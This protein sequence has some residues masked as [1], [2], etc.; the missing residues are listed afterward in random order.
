MTPLEIK[1]KF[2]QYMEKNLSYE[3]TAV[4]VYALLD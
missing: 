1:Q 2:D 4:E 3:H